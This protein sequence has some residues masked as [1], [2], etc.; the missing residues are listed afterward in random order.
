MVPSAMADL[1][2]DVVVVTKRYGELVAVDPISLRSGSRGG[3]LVSTV[4]PVNGAAATTHTTLMLP[5]G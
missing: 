1:A 5:P 3:T 2:V 4:P